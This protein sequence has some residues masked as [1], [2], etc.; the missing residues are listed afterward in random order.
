MQKNRAIVSPGGGFGVKARIIKTIPD[1]KTELEIFT[2]STNQIRRSYALNL[3]NPC[4]VSR[5][6]LLFVFALVKKYIIDA[7]VRRTIGTRF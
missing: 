6:K 1:L 5:I 7:S 4:F 3:Q 2:W